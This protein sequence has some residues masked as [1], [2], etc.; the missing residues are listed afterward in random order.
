MRLTPPSDNTI[1]VAHFLASVNNFIEHALRDVEDSDM[2][3]MTIH[4]QVNQND[5][6]I[7]FSFRRREQVSAD[8]LWSVFQKVSQS[9]SRFNA[10]NTLVV[11]VHSVKMP[12]GFGKILL[13]SRGR[14]LSV[15]AHLKKRI[16]GNQNKEISH[17]CYM[18]SLK[19]VL[20]PQVIR[21]CTSSTI[22]R[23]PKTPI[24]RTRLNYTYLTSFACSI[25]V[26]V[27]RMRKT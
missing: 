8:V 1:P 18:I 7:G 4:N 5:S 6:P 21:Y 19:D 13:K 12:V 26:R 10:L 15:N 11:T 24:T 23:R 2:V 20:P 16:V 25:S 27:A 22:S 9:N 3:G 14:P 17:L